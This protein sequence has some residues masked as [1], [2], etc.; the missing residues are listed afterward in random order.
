[1]QLNKR[2]RY[3]QGHERNSYDNDSKAELEPSMRLKNEY[4][5]RHALARYKWKLA[6]TGR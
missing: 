1:M 4:A 5:G 2:L 6:K 3:E